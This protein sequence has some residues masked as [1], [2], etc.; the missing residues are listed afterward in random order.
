MFLPRYVSLSWVRI[1]C[2]R[3]NNFS[4]NSIFQAV[5]A[6]CDIFSMY[7]GT[8]PWLLG[9]SSLAKCSNI[10]VCK[11]IRRRRVAD[12]DRT[13]IHVTTLHRRGS[14][15]HTRHDASQTGIVLAY[16]SRRVTDGDRTSIH[17]TTRHRRGSYWHTRHDASQTG[18]V[19]AYTS[20]RVT[21]GDRTSIHVT[22]RLTG[23]YLFATIC[24][25]RH[26]RHDAI[27]CLRR[28]VFNI[29]HVIYVIFEVFDPGHLFTAA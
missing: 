3:S 11:K 16:T 20:R 8:V 29:K 12:G 28:F 22:T 25:F 4:S 18:I 15:W 1:S 14:Y 19:L 7:L 21:D 24:L 27:I 13:G 26:T 10:S 23:N 6:A 2:Q 17:V 5:F 9:C